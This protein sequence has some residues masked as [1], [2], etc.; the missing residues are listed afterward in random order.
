MPTQPLIAGAAE[1][2]HDPR[3]DQPGEPAGHQVALDVHQQSE[4][5]QYSD[6][7]IEVVLVEAGIDEQ[8]A[9]HGDPRGDEILRDDDTTARIDEDASRQ[10]VRG[11]RLGAAGVGDPRLEVADG[12][13][14]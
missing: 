11:A 9:E 8:E 14:G 12:V 2:S 1:M 13:A 3:M 5:D 4:G 10:V 6:H 7:G